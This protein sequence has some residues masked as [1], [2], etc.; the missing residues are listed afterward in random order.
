MN[1]RKVFHT[2]GKINVLNSLMMLIPMVVSII[3]REKCAFAFLAAAVASFIFG[4]ALSHFAKIKDNSIYAKEGFVIVVLTWLTLSVFGA[5]P[6]VISGEIS[7]FI[8][9]F[10]ETV[11]GFT[12]TGASILTNVESMSKGLLFWRS[13]THWIGGMGVLVFV[14]AFLPNVSDRSM[15]IL[16]AEMPGPTVDKFVPKAR[17]T[18]KIALAPRLDLFSVP[19]NSSIIWST[20]F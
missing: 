15:H 12:T 3:Y 13:F 6:F 16:K 5:L 9:A 10:F 19:S 20:C 11:S 7:S 14:M 18:A 1:R 4:F 2:V 17:D 8:D